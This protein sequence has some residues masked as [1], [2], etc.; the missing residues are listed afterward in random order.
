MYDEL[1][2]EIQEM[3]GEIY[4]IPELKDDE[5]GDYFTDYM[6]SNYDY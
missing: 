6:N 1:W 2:Q 5:E 3:P 4:D